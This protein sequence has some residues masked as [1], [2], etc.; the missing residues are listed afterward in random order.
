MNARSD[1]LHSALAT[2][3]SDQQIGQ[4]AV[5]IPVAT[6]VFRRLK[7]DFCCGGQV[8]LAKAAADKGLDAAAVL[9]ELQ[10]LQRS[11]AVPDAATPTE[12][13]DHILVRYH[14]VHRQQLPEL[15]RM[16]RRV[17]AVHRDNPDVPVGRADHLET[18]HE[19]LLSHMLKEEQVL[20]PMLRTGGNR[21]ATRTASRERQA[22]KGLL[23]RAGY[24]FLSPGVKNS[25]RPTAISA[26]GHH[27]RSSSRRLML[28]SPRFV[29]RKNTPSTTS[30]T[31][32]M[33]PF[34]WTPPHLMFG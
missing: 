26:T 34:M 20:F 4:L 33:F 29:S 8:S 25:A 11:D 28:M 7:L 9:A 24:F 10:S 21:R 13:I 2:L 5:Q 3:S 18:M 1:S 22:R 12:L 17:E 19:E 32:A 16:A 15:I 30:T 23:R 31:A 6:A 14:E 27:T